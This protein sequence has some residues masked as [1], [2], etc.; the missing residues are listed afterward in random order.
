MNFKKKSF[1][2][3]SYLKWFNG[4]ILIDKQLSLNNF[5][6]DIKKRQ[7]F[8]KYHQK[9]IKTKKSYLVFKNEKNIQNR[10]HICCLTQD[11][12]T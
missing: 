6:S 5:I 1:K 12:L 11:A 2:Q 7:T 4:D 9:D 8:L 3:H 10:L